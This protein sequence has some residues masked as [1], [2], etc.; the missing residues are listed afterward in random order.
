MTLQQKKRQDEFCNEQ[1]IQGGE[2]AFALL[3]QA[4]LAVRI[5]A[6]WT[7]SLYIPSRR[8][9]S[10]RSGRVHAVPN[11]WPPNRLCWFGLTTRRMGRTDSR[12]QLCHLLRSRFLSIVE[13]SCWS[14]C[15][16][17]GLS[18]PLEVFRAP[19]RNRLS[20][21]NVSSSLA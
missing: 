18:S 16:Q 1:E 20:G 14:P 5:H 8:D 3:V 19:L 12:V 13:L 21:D 6:W 4:I 7:K 17:F 15:T 2:E 10:V 11:P 9:R